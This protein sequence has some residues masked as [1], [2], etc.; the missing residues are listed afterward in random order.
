MWNTTRSKSPYTLNGTW[1]TNLCKPKKKNLIPISNQGC[2]KLSK[3]V[4]HAFIIEPGSKT[5]SLFLSMRSIKSIYF[6]GHSHHVIY[7]CLKSG[8]WKLTPGLL[9][10]QI[11]SF[12]LQCTQE[13]NDFDPNMCLFSMPWFDC[14]IILYINTRFIIILID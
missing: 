8:V 2:I 3:Y 10:N 7:L 12:N 6:C 13:I 5:T 14:C 4:V 11:S 1:I 9:A